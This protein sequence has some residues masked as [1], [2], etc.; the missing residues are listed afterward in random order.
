MDDP[1]AKRVAAQGHDTSEEAVDEMC[2]AG[3][4][5]ALDYLL[6]DV[7]AVLVPDAAHDLAVQLSHDL[8]LVLSG[9]DLWAEKGGQHHSSGYL[10]TLV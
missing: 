7:V 5:D 3:G 10:D 8:T 1:A 9:Q 6:N 4:G 2:D